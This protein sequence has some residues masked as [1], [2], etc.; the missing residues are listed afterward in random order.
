MHPPTAPAAAAA[1]AT[2][3]A[4][5]APTTAPAGAEASPESVGTTQGPPSAQPLATAAP[6]PSE[7][8]DEESLPEVPLELEQEADEESEGEA[9]AA[10][11]QALEPTAESF[12]MTAPPEA[13]PAEAVPAPAEEPLPPHEV[14]QPSALELGASS[15]EVPTD[16]H[17]VHGAHGVPG[18]ARGLVAP[19][20]PDLA[21]PPALESELPQDTQTA[22]AAVPNEST[23]PAPR[24]ARTPRAP[25][26]I[27]TEGPGEEARPLQLAQ[28]WEL[29]QWESGPTGTE[30]ALSVENAEPERSEKTETVSVWEYMAWQRDREARREGPQ[31]PPTLEE[32]LRAARTAQ[33]PELAARAVLA[34]LSDQFRR[35]FF[36]VESFGQLLVWNPSLPRPPAPEALS[37]R[38]FTDQPS[39]FS[40]VAQ[41][42]AAVGVSSGRE[43][44]D[45]LVFRLLA[46][47]GFAALAP[48][49]C[50]ERPLAYLWADT[51]LEAASDEVLAQLSALAQALATA[52]SAQRVGP[53]EPPGTGFDSEATLSE[54][55]APP[56]S[57][58][59]DT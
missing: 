3:T 54:P 17:S 15:A 53:A 56:G 33:T 12:E 5:H 22:I 44:Q 13:V 34:Y 37:L 14:Q 6:E 38:V 11:A 32:A 57:D 46:P 4:P 47:D 16:L 26:E 55:S 29:V 10:P 25:I 43:G 19:P 9:A 59:N 20:A 45:D 42:R 49:S 1:A 41:L 24:A 18:P 52:L 30:R 27:D 40:D 39:V 35:A 7:L 23:S 51:G 36:V 28:T 8:S 2:A 50:P 31:A 48:V 58:R 21:S